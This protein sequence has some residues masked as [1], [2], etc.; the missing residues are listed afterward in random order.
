MTGH[1]EAIAKLR[2]GFVEVGVVAGE[3]SEGLILRHLEMVL[4][5]NERVNLTAITNLSEMAL[6]HAVDSATVLRQASLGDGS[7]VL[8][9]GSGAG[10]PGIT[11]KCLVPGI[12]V[13]LAE[14]LGKRC[15]FL[16]AVGGELFP[17]NGVGSS[18]FEVAWG[19]AEDLGR[20]V[21]FRDGFDLVVARAVA[22]LRVLVEYCLPFV[23]PGGLF[24]AM[25]GPDLQ[26]EMTQA[27]RAI[28]LVGGKVTGIDQ[29]RLP[30]GAGERTLVRI[31]KL[32][33][34]PNRYPRKAGIP[35]KSPL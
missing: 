19:R 22:E 18:G 10:F 8:D 27:E 13:A 2:Q 14:S 7:R 25:K 26:K 5:W 33:T 28:S 4:E 23:R 1:D 31:Q 11:L 29:F 9:V 20:D 12:R 24:V 30:F 16:E 34:T 32:G 6:K 17:G 35:A 15:R 21:Q 3:E